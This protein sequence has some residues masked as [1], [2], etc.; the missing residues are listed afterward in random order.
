M[1]MKNEHFNRLID[2]SCRTD[3]SLRTCLILA[4][5]ALR[6]VIAVDALESVNMRRDLRAGK[7]GP[8]FTQKAL[9][10]LQES[11]RRLRQHNR[12]LLIDYGRFLRDHHRAIEAELGWD[13]LCDVLCVHPVHRAEAGQLDQGLFGITW[14]GGQF[15]DSATHYGSE[16]TGE[17]PVTRAIGAAMLDWMKN[18]IKKMPDPTAPGGPLYGIPTYH[19]QPDGTMARQSA[20]LVVHDPDGSTRAVERKIEV[21]RP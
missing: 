1:L 12:D 16:L 19:P 5:R 15:E 7:R 14:I 17:G 3:M 21:R 11:Y 10:G 8:P 6:H 20:P 9:D 4:R 18:N 13:G 2:L